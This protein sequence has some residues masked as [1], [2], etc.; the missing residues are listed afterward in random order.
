MTTSQFINVI[1]TSTIGA[2]SEQVLL[3]YNPYGSLYKIH[4]IAVRIEK[5]NLDQLQQATS[6]SLKGPLED[7]LQIKVDNSSTPLREVDRQVVTQVSGGQYYVYSILTE[8]QRVV[9]SNP[10]SALY[11]KDIIIEP[12]IDITPIILQNYAAILGTVDK[13]RE[14]DYIVHSDREYATSGSKTNP[15]NLASILTNQ[16]QPASVQDS[17]YTSTGWINGR[18]EGSKLTYLNNHGANPFLK[19]AFFQ[20]SFFDRNIADI[21]IK[22]L[23]P[24]DL[25]YSEYFFSGELDSLR[26]ELEDTLFNISVLS[27][28]STTQNYVGLAAGA[29]VIPKVLNI[30]DLLVIQSGSAGNYYPEVLQMT[31]PAPGALP[32]YF[33]YTYY[34]Q[35][36]GSGATFATMR[37]NRGVNDTPRIAQ[38]NSGANVKVF[39]IVPTT[40]Y[41][42]AGNN[43]QVARKGKMRASESSEVVY[44]GNQGA[45]YSGSKQDS[46]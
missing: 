28:D 39:R 15:V 44:I 5:G 4:A 30:G 22:E 24:S 10:N 17:N 32:Q 37:I 27:I 34:N 20:G 11:T 41:T 45:V 36:S 43:I 3:N 38:S 2:L 6:I 16:A 25:T 12:G 7:V 26:Y 19:G 18:Y 42:I 40:V 14:S 21:Y 29:W 1:S 46:L 13:S 31:T 9:V 8:N 23:P 33:P 35:N